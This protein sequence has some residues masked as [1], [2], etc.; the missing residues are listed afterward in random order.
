[1]YRVIHS[2]RCEVQQ[3]GRIIIQKA[4]TDSDTY[5]VQEVTLFYLLHV[6]CTVFLLLGT[7]W[8]FLLCF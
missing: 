3:Q 6:F 8:T 2:N 5:N 7:S 4:Q 1:M